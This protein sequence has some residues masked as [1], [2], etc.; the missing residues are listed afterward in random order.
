MPYE[1]A[2]AVAATFAYEIRYALTPLFGKGFIAMCIHPGAPDFGSFKIARKLIL[3]CTAE[4]EQWRYIDD[5]RRSLCKSPTIDTSNASPTNYSSSPGNYGD[6]RT[7]RNETESG[8]GTD[9]DSDKHYTV[10]I[11]RQKSYKSEWRPRNDGFAIPEIS[12]VSCFKSHQTVA[13][14]L[15]STIRMEAGRKDVEQDEDDHFTETS[16]T[17]GTAR[18][19][20]LGTLSHRETKAAYAMMQLSFADSTLN[21]YSRDR[22]RKTFF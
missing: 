12:A 11:D 8:Y 19:S 10:P 2:K 22:D 3:S 6:R 20:S 1:A 14:L 5:D 15:Q 21:K 7:K 16:S 4:A 17:S 18:R 13:G 9:T